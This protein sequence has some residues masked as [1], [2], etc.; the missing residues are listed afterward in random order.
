MPH[1]QARPSAPPD[2]TLKQTDTTLD[3]PARYRFSTSYPHP[4]VRA[5][6]R[7]SRRLPS[8]PHKPPPPSGTSPVIL[9]IPYTVWTSGQV[10]GDVAVARACARPPSPSRAEP[11]GPG[12]RRPAV[13]MPPAWR[14]RSRSRPPHDSPTRTSTRS[15]IVPPRPR[16]AGIHILTLDPGQPPRYTLNTDAGPRPGDRARQPRSPPPAP[17]PYRRPAPCTKTMHTG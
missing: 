14:N 12:R 15:T 5:S 1:H 17:T 7:D 13:R 16:Y 10:Q 4:Q 9:L 11:E 2:T 8:Y 6:C 3:T